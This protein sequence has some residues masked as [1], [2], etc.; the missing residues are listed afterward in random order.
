MVK[1]FWCNGDMVKFSNGES[2]FGTHF[3]QCWNGEKAEFNLCIQVNIVVGV[4]FVLGGNFWWSEVRLPGTK[5]RGTVP[6]VF[7][8]QEKYWQHLTHYWNAN[9]PGNCH[10]IKAVLTI[11]LPPCLLSMGRRFSNILFLLDQPLCSFWYKMYAYHRT[12]HRRRKRTGA[13]AVIA[14]RMENH[15]YGQARDKRHRDSYR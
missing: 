12:H 15:D 10:G 11:I 8:P 5:S 6:G 13:G 1:S 2:F 14:R 3:H 9:C 7:F 4:N